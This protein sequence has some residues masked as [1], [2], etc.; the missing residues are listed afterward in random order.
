MDEA[1]CRKALWGLT[2]SL[3]AN[4]HMPSVWSIGHTGYKHRMILHLEQLPRKVLLLPIVI[5]ITTAATIT[6]TI[7]TLA[8]TV[9]GTGPRLPL[10]RN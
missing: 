7:T 2:K 3:A 1:G 10:S 4:S 9:F 8:F 6:T 5:D